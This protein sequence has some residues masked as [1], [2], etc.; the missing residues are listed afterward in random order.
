MNST[1]ATAYRERMLR[2]LDHVDR[3]LDGDLTLDALSAVAAFSKHHFH[4][5]FSAMFGLSVHRYV[6][7]ARLK[8]ASYRLVFREEVPIIE[9]ALDSGYEAPEAFARAFKERL[10]Q[11]PRAFRKQP[12]WSPW[13]AAY[14]PFH[15]ARTNQ[16]STPTDDQIRIVD[17]PATRVAILKHRGDPRTIGDT[18]K[19]FIAWRKETGVR[20]PASATF[21]IL[22]NDPETSAADDYRLDLCA[23]ISAPIVPNDAGIFDSEIAGGRCAVLRLVGSGDDLRAAI[24]YL[25]GNWLPS[26]GEEPR[27]AP[28]FVQRVRFFPDVPEHEAITDIFLPLQYRHR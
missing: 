28:L 17:F 20:P 24:A 27:D 25:Y 11:S 7:L 19:R 8:R 1:A 16:M 26:S 5:Q 22:H 6:Q 21:N 9:I 13:H 10:G 3:N 4:R 15:R 23:E 14:A 2:V 18:I 12:D